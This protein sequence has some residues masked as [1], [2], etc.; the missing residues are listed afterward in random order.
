[1]HRLALSAS[2][3]RANQQSTLET[4][5]KIVFGGFGRGATFLE[6]P[7]WLVTQTN[8][9]RAVST[10]VHE[11][12]DKHQGAFIELIE[13]F[14]RIAARPVDDRPQH[15][16]GFSI[17]TPVLRGAG[18]AA[19]FYLEAHA[20]PKPFFLVFPQMDAVTEAMVWHLWSDH[21]FKDDLNL[22]ME[23]SL[24]PRPTLLGGWADNAGH[25]YRAVRPD[26]F[27]VDAQLA[28]KTGH[29]PSVF[30]IDNDEC[31]RAYSV[32]KKGVLDTPAWIRELFDKKL[33]KQHEDKK[34]AE[35]DQEPPK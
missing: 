1:M 13:F 21:F 7:A 19:K 8:I 2:I 24:L 12:R 20:N 14:S 9:Y 16:P 27:S 10:F 34:E 32:E 17:P 26:D 15:L 4:G 22:A 29:A 33:G 5:W 18:Y 35:Q 23:E 11:E 3:E 30:S 25:E 31:L 6:D 28:A